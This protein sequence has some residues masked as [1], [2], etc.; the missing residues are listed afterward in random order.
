[1]HQVRRKGPRGYE[2]LMREL[3][4]IEQQLMV[5]GMN[6]I[7]MDLMV[8]EAQIRER[9]QILG[10]Q[11]DPVTLLLTDDFLKAEE[12]SI[13]DIQALIPKELPPFPTLQ[14]VAQTRKTKRKIETVGTAAILAL[15]TALGVFGLASFLQLALSW[16]A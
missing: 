14:D 10:N 3:E 6:S 15:V 7:A 8:L 2:D 13:D 1:M 4:G 9:F 16:I 11:R 12:L 5:Q